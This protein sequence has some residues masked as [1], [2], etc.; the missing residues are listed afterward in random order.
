[1]FFADYVE[2]TD[3]GDLIDTA[4]L[5][6]HMRLSQQDAEDVADFLMT[7]KEHA[8]L[9]TPGAYEP[10]RIAKKLGEMNFVKFKGCAACH[11][12]APGVGG[13]SGPEVY[14]AFERLRPDW[15][16]NY[17]RNPQ[18]WDPRIFMPNR[19]LNDQDISKLIDY[20]R[21]LSEEQ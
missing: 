20:L 17:I 13:L 6:T 3:E 4:R 16:V 10:A 9:V 2:V 14:T 1:M 8:D 18:A 12:I 11:E 15:M 19:H 7:L 5:P 21:V